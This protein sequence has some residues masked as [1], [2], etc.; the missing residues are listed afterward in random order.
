[1][2]YIFNRN[3]FSFII[4]AYQEIRQESLCVFSMYAQILPVYFLNTFKYFQSFRRQF[5]Y[6]PPQICYILN[7]CLN[8]FCVF[9]EQTQILSAHSSYMHKYCTFPMTTQQ[10]FS[11]S[12]TPGNFKGTVFQKNR[13]G[14][15]YR[16]R[17][18]I[19]QYTNLIFL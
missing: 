19:E 17:M 13:W 14:I 8:T 15:I 1:M 9:S 12:R 7:I 11:L 5:I 18:K 3:M 10:K 16:P 4:L 6:K 2:L